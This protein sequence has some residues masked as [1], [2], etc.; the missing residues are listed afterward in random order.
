MR[1]RRIQPLDFGGGAVGM[2]HEV[3]H[4]ANLLLHVVQRAGG[5]E[6]DNAQPFFFQ[7]LPRRALGEAPGDDDVRPQNQYVLG[8]AG[9]FWELSGLCRIP[10]SRAIAGI[11]AETENL[12]R[13]RQRHQQLIGAEIDRGDPRQFGGVRGALQADGGQDGD[14]HKR[15]SQPL[16]F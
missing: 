11:G 2:L 7:Q 4:L 9:E 5:I 16:A 6:F 14:R 13:V 8:L 10:G 15:A 12:R 3:A 1:N